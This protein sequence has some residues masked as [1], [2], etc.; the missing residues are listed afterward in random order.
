MDLYR[1]VE[2]FAKEVKR[3]KPDTREFEWSD[4]EADIQERGEDKDEDFKLHGPWKK[5]V[6]NQ[7]GLKVYAVDGKWIRDNLSV[8]FG[9]GGHMYVHEFI[10]EDEIWIVTHHWDE[11]PHSKC[12]CVK[13]NKPVSQEYFDSCTVHEI[14]ERKRMKEEEPYWKAHNESLDEERD[15]GLLKNP[16]KDTGTTPIP[17][18]WPGF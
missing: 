14:E 1:A 9:H 10:P 7:D 17:K 12:S 11:N 6:R 3:T 18:D 5:F 8:I 13:G 15:L 16:D 4:I 2:R